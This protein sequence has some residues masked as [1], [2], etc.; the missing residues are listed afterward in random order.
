MSREIWIGP[1]PLTHQFFAIV[2]T[3]TGWAVCLAGR[4]GLGTR[5]MTPHNKRFDTKREAKEWRDQILASKP[6]DYW[7]APEGKYLLDENGELRPCF[8]TKTTQVVK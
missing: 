3:S 5:Y 2:R 4:Q 1:A 7:I 6:S 8:K